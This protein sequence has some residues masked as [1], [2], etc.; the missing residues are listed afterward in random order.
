M[1]KIAEA[2][3][4]LIVLL[5]ADADCRCGNFDLHEDKRREALQTLVD[6][7]SDDERP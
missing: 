5:A 2:V 1:M 7:V 4:I 3:E 6:A